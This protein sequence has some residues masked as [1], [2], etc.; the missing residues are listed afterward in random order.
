MFLHRLF[1]VQL[2]I[3][4]PKF[5]YAAKLTQSKYGIIR[6]PAAGERRENS[7]IV[8]IIKSQSAMSHAKEK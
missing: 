6:Y 2:S 5:R 3:A 8:A 1:S 7:K 4:T